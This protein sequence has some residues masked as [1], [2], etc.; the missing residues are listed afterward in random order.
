MFDINVFQ[1]K[2]YMMFYK[3]KN[4]YF[5]VKTIQKVFLKKLI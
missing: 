5:H 2:V 1:V 3:E 4:I